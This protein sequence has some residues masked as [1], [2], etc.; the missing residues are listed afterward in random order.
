MK[1][2]KEL[3]ETARVKLLQQ[4]EH[5]LKML[6]GARK[7]VETFAPEPEEQE[8]ESET[9]SPGCKKIVSREEREE[10]KE[11]KPRRVVVR[12]GETGP[13]KFSDLVRQAI[14]K[15]KGQFSA[16]DVK[17][18][19]EAAAP[20]ELKKRSP[21]VVG[22]TLLGMAERGE[23][24]RMKEGSST[25]YEVPQKAAAKQG[26]TAHRAVSTQSYEEKKKALNIHVP[27]DPDVIP[28]S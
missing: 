5:E 28:A 24:I 27:R 8:P 13:G 7:L 4:H 6:D 2:L 20:G 26:E 23:L 21:E 9:P 15:L 16:A 1:A 25:F 14:G 12:A 11:A 22:V 18:Q 10:H 19:I 17:K 3:F